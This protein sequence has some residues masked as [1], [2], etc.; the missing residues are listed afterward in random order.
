VVWLL[1]NGGDYYPSSIIRSM[2]KTASAAN[3]KAHAV[4]SQPKNGAAG[5]W[6]VTT[7]TLREHEILQLLSEG[8]RAR[9]SPT[10]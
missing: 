8:R 7:L 4:Y 3:S 1:L 10:G 5:A 6:P 9:S 2:T